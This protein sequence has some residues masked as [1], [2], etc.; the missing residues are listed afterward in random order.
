MR[1]EPLKYH[2][3]KMEKSS[4]QPNKYCCNICDKEFA[5]QKQ[6]KE[7]NFKEHN[8]EIDLQ[9]DHCL[10]TFQSRI[11]F[12]RHWRKIYEEKQ[13]EID[14]LNIQLKELE[15]KNGEMEKALAAEKSDGVANSK[16]ETLNSNTDVKNLKQF[17]CD[18][19]KE[20]F[21][22]LLSHITQIH[23]DAA[24]TM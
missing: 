15:A 1:G 24:A 18:Y 8:K 13:Q 22:T 19:C 11:M 20:N 14:T 3:D 4:K 16:P 2:E 7:H 10:M 9:C 6:L 21:A 17:K 23:K 5:L 12:A